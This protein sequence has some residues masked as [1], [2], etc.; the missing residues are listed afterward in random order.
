MILSFAMLF[1]CVSTA[2]RSNGGSIAVNILCATVISTLFTAIGLLLGTN[3]ALND[4]WIG[5]VVSKLAD[6]TSA[7]GDVIH[8]IIVA[9]AWGIASIIAGITLFQKADVK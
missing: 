2:V 4:Y 7:S 5:G 1:T 9:A 8:G 6:V 3:I